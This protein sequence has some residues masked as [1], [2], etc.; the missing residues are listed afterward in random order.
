MKVILYKDVPNLGEEG[1]VKIVAAG[2]ARN[3]LI[4]KKFAVPYNK[5][6]EIELA[7]KQQ[8]INRRKA[9]RTNDA[10][11]LKTRIE[12]VEMEIAAA[13]GEQGRLFGSVTSS[14]I[15]N[16][17]SSQGIKIERKRVKLPD[18][19]IKSV[20]IHNVIIRLYGDQLAELRVNVKPAGAKRSEKLS[21]E[22]EELAEDLKDAEVEE[23]P[24]I[25]TEVDNTNYPSKGS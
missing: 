13:A 10:S 21:S 2:Y 12:T 4:P 3:F 24:K 6:T 19:G 23:N 25:K 1:D 22:K 14:A 11:S 16:Y 18:E 15:V 5:A 8:A 20:G 7:Q 17:L 9:E